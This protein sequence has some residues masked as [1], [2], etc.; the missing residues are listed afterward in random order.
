MP[1]QAI[2]HRPPN[3]GIPLFD[4]VEDAMEEYRRIEADL[5]GYPRGAGC[6]VTI[7]YCAWQ[8]K[9]WVYFAT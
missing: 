7:R 2:E 5:Y 4:K 1:L 6:A 8:G 9:Q 3:A